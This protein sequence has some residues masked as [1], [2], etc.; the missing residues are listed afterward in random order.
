MRVTRAAL[1]VLLFVMTYAPA[2]FA[3]GAP[4]ASATS[5]AKPSTAVATFAGG[6]FWS[7]EVTFEGRPGVIS[8]TSGYTGGTLKN[9]TYE[10]VGTR[11]TG[12]YESVNIVY[13]PAKTTYEKL[14]DIYWHNIDPM[15]A[16]G[17]FCDHGPEYGSAIFFHDETQHRLALET[18]KQIEAS[19][20]LKN[21]IVTQIL[22]AS[23]FYPAEEYH[24]DFYKKNWDYYHEYRVGCGRDARLMQIWGKLD[25]YAPGIE[26]KSSKH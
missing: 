10:D 3:A 1:T 24:Q 16:D 14:L 4:A 26:P 7:E 8:V 5:P 23:V 22:P 9:P 2:A 21:P 17:A 11:T 12:H 20:K 19:G 6:C 13:D 15:Q 25:A 18:K